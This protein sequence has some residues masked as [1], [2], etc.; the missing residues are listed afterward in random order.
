[1]HIWNH[2]LKA[3]RRPDARPS[4]TERDVRR[5]DTSK[6]MALQCI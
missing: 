6:H 2:G 4:G 1:M 3:G 5:V